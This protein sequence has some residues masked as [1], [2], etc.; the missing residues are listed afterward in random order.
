[1]SFPKPFTF[2]QTPPPHASGND[3]TPTPTRRDAKAKGK[4]REMVWEE[5]DEGGG[6]LACATHAILF[7]LA[8]R[9]LSFD[10]GGRPSARQVKAELAHLIARSHDE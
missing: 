5:D 8:Q 7:A 10:A 9:L 6:A 1:M 2:G 3:P 4:G